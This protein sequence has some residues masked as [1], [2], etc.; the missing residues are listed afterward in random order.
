MLADKLAIAFKSYFTGRRGDGAIACQFSPRR[1]RKLSSSNNSTIPL[2]KSWSLNRNDGASV[3]ELAVQQTTGVL[4][5]P[6]LS[7]PL[8]KPLPD[9]ST[10][11]R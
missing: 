10:I 2:Q 7:A 4:L 5:L 6:F 3:A 9:R 8:L 1:S 11:G